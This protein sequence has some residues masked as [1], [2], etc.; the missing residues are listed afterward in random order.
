MGRMKDEFMKTVDDLVNSASLFELNNLFPPLSSISEENFVVNKGNYK[1]TVT[2]R[3]NKEGQA[4]STSC[5][6]VYEPSEKELK[7]AELKKLLQQ[8]VAA[9]EFLLANEVNNRIK[10]LESNK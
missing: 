8:H 2:V 1:T 4:I 5:N 6:S 3:F 7:L 10:E 9:K